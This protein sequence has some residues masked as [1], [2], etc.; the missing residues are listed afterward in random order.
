MTETPPYNV[1]DVVNGHRWTGTEW[2]PVGTPPGTPPGTAT[3]AAPPKKPWFKKWWGVGLI[4]FAVL[5]VLGVAFGGGGDTDT[6]TADESTASA[7]QTPGD[8]EEPA[9]ELTVAQAN[10]LGSAEDYLSFSA[11]SKKGLVN[12]LSSDI[13]GY[14]KADAEWAVEQLDVDW[15]EQAARSAE[16]YLEFS[17]FSRSGLINQLTADIEGYTKAQAEYAADAVGL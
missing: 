14:D 16:S 3:P 10:A 15:K 7:E 17:S 6:V 5:V 2:E 1:G 13:E 11:F 4:A 12:Q 8:K 9:E